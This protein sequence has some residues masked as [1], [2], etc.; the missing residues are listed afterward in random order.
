MR[1]GLLY[2]S[3][4]LVWTAHFGAVYGLAS[5]GD[6]T[7]GAGAP[8]WRVAIGAAT[9]AAVAAVAA[10]LVLLWRAR[11]SARLP[12]DRMMI[13]LALASGG[14]AAL[15]IVWQGLPAAMLG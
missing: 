15:A 8:L 11:R 3:P 14:L 7:T 12:A 9:A 5:L 4:W 2:M 13:D 6:I 10:A 1:R